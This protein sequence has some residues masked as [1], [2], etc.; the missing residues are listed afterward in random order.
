MPEVSI[1]MPVFNDIRFVEKAIVSILNQSFHDFELLLSDDCSSDGS[2]AVCKKYALADAR[3]KY[4]RQDANIGISKNMEFLLRE[5]TGKYFM[6]A[7]NDDVWDKEFVRILKEN[8]ENNQ[9]AVSSFCAYAQV[10]EDDNYIAGR[11]FIIEDYVDPAKSGRIKK[12][13]RRNGDGFGYGLFVREKILGVK[14]PVW[15]WVNRKCAY[16]NIYPTLCFYLARGGY[17]IYDKRVLW[18]NRIKKAEN[19]NHKIPFTDSFIKCYAA[20]A[21]RKFN[22]V[23]VSLASV[24]KADKGIL[25]AIKVL[26]R[27]FFSWFMVPV[28]LSPRQRYRAFREKEFSSF[29]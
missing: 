11:E 6:W 27:M 21:L 25:T 7:A 15:W 3:V 13:I 26:P 16:N 12:L 28:F 20:F 10:D 22:L 23:W 18:F 17:A 24:I 1:G 2:A 4:I 9:E 29:I 8:L 14:F 19:I 5:S